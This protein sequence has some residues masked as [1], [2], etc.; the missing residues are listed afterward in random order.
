MDE[1]VR[2][3]LCY[4]INFLIC[5]SRALSSIAPLAP[6]DN[7]SVPVDKVGCEEILPDSC[8]SFLFVS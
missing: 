2:S 8:D 1:S 7:F 5:A 6:G 3:L 4:F